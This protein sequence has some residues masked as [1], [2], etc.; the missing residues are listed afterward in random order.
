MSDHLALLCMFGLGE[1]TSKLA[2]WVRL[3]TQC[4]AVVDLSKEQRAIQV[5]ASKL[6]K[7][8]G[9]VEELREDPGFEWILKDESGCQGKMPRQLALL[10]YIVMVSF[11][12]PWLQGKTTIKGILLQ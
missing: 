10:D 11:T 3:L 7:R 6:V 4:F 1:P 12:T 8:T 2:Y 9:N 5:A